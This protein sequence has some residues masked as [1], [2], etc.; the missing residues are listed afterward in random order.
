MLKDKNALDCPS[1]YR[2]KNLKEKTKKLLNLLF[3][4]L[5][6]KIYLSIY[7]TWINKKTIMSIFISFINFWI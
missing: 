1:N 3:K 2:K 6:P 4:F 7:Y 5:N